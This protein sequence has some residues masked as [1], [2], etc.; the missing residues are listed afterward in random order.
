GIGNGNFTGQVF[1]IDKTAP[2]IS[3]AATTSPNAAGWYD[4][5]SVTVH[6]TCADA[7]TGIASCPPDVTLSAEGANQ[8][9]TGTATDN[10]GNSA[11]ATVSGIN[12]D[13]TAPTISGTPTTSPAA[14]GWNSSVTTVPSSSADTSSGTRSSSADATLAEGTGQSST[15]TAT[16]KAGNSASTTVSGINIDKTA[17]T[18]SGAA[19]TSPIAAGWYNS[20]VTAH[21]SCSDT[22][23]GIQSC[24]ADATLA[25]GNGESSSG[26]ATDKDGNSTSTTAT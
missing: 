18:I 23:S 7:L 4:G 1:T 9:V 3:G 19:T 16:D 26:T 6:F 22:L 21:F 8:S 20:D 12:I 14:G 11:S 10:A 17:P 5:G 2:T 25:D 15:G 13:K 24:A